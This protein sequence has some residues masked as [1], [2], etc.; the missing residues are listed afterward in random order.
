MIQKFIRFTET[1]ETTEVR[2]FGVTISKETITMN[3]QN[4]V[5]KVKLLG[6]TLKTETIIDQREYG[7]QT[8]CNDTDKT[9]NSSNKITRS[10]Y[11]FH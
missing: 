8:S 7:I 11:G 1:T 10:S 5:R 4:E 6:L 3:S 2:F 9:P